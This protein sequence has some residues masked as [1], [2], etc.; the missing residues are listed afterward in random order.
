MSTRIR[1]GLVG[2]LC[3]LVLIG[4]AIFTPPDGQ[5]RGDLAR[6]FGDFHPLAV[7]LPIALLLLVPVLEI[8]GRN[9]RR[10]PLRTAAGFVLGLAALSAIA[11]PCLGWLLA[12]SGG[13][14]GGLVTQHM[15]GGISVATG[16]LL[17]WMLRGRGVEVDLGR[18]RL[19]ASYVGLLAVTVGVMAWTGYRGGQL[20]HGENH[21]TEHLPPLAKIWLGLPVPQKASAS[22]R[23]S[24]FY[25]ARVAPL[26]EEHCLLCHSAGKR[27]GGL[28]LDSYERLLTGGKGG[29]VIKPGDAKGSELFRRV[30]LDPASKDF[31]PKEGKPPLGQDD[32]K[33]L[34]LWINAGASQTIAVN[35]IA[36]APV[37]AKPAAPLAPDYRPEKPTIAQLESSLGI[38]LVPRSQDPRDGLVLRTASSPARCD[39]VALTKLAPVARYIVDAE[40]ART[41]VTDGGL[42]AIAGF[43][44]LRSLDLSHTAITSAGLS[45]LAKLPKL[46]VL[47]LTGTSVDDTGIA[48]LRKDKT[49]KHMYLFQTNVTS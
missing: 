37:L 31:M 42:K 34:E 11:A 21:L 44:N 7:H 19:P 33:L 18:G 14:E 43:T 23:A 26:F 3:I 35:A 12:W 49:L 32:L 13:F 36:G 45:E 9:P 10:G 30:S 16:S 20:A 2:L 25:A 29:V 48:P 17:C 8:A 4:L 40:L 38:R 41:K 15:W 46:E 28:R 22:D 47:N 5:E 1:L 39:D 6:F 24:T 27:K